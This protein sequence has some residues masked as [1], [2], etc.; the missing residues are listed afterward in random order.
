MFLDHISIAWPHLQDYRSQDEE[1]LYV[2]LVF[3]FFSF[4][5]WWEENN[6]EKSFVISQKAVILFLFSYDHMHYS[7]RDRRVFAP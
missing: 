4:G 7:G 2:P 1:I 3:F 6:N 5:F